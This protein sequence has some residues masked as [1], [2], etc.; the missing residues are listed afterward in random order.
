[1]N[2]DSSKGIADRTGADRAA[3]IHAIKQRLADLE[4]CWPQH[5]VPPAMLQ[6]LEDLEDQLAELEG[7][8]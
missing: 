2:Q 6:D 1:M 8:G 4:A 7:E 5:S 3:Q